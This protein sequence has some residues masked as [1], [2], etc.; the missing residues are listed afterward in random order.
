MVVDTNAIHFQFGEYSTSEIVLSQ[1]HDPQSTTTTKSLRHTT[2]IREHQTRLF[3]LNGEQHV[4]RR[5]LPRSITPERS[6]NKCVR[7]SLRSQA[8]GLRDAPAGAMARR[9]IDKSPT[10]ALRSTVSII[11]RT[12]KTATRKRG[13]N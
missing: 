1:L 5:Y 4:A 3:T 6:D 11:A 10:T 2:S 12:M 9:E 8:S 7:D 13:S